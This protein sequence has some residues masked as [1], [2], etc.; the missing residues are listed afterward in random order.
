MSLG[1]ALVVDDEKPLARIVGSYLEREGFEVFVTYDGESA[2]EFAKN[3][4]PHLIVLDIMLPG[5]DGIEVCK[6]LREFT[7][8]YI[9]MLTARDD[10]A[11]KVIALSTGAD[12]YLVKPFSS[13]ELVARAHAML[14]RPRG[15]R[16]LHAPAWERLT[17]GELVLDAHARRA[18][19]DGRVIQMTRTEYDILELLVRADGAVV[20]REEII[21]A[22]RGGDW[23]GDPQ[24]ID[25][26]VARL[27]GKLHDSARDSRFILT[28]RGVGDQWGGDH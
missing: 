5:L 22:I 17:T 15:P 14:R 13:K 10:P 7:D 28:V 12:D 21:A 6:K 20:T 24:M 4:R 3:E 18:E 9:L 16:G 25:A 11:D 27:R 19:L 26:H 2:I 1:R 8:A 23:F